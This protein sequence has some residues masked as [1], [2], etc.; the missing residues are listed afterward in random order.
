MQLFASVSSIVLHT[1]SF[2]RMN[3]VVIVIDMPWQD[4]YAKRQRQSNRNQTHL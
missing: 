2:N 4:L 3:N 1:H